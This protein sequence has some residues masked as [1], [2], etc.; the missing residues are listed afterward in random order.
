MTAEDEADYVRPRDVEM[1]GDSLTVISRSVGLLICGISLPGV[2]TL[3]SRTRGKGRSARNTNQHVKPT[4]TRQLNR[5]R[6]V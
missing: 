3:W 2:V 5:A 1:V 6:H 4:L